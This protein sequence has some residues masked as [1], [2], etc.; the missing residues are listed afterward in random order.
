MFQHIGL[1]YS[2]QFLN[3]ET[4]SEDPEF[5]KMSPF[6]STPL[7]ESSLDYFYHANTI[8][9]YISKKYHESGL[10]GLLPR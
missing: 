10:T 5:L 3:K 8:I 1:H 4:Y 6:G 9:R 7:L 2:L